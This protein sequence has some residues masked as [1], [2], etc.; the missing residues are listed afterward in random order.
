MFFDSEFMRLYEELCVI[1]STPEVSLTE[2]KYIEAGPINLADCR[3]ITSDVKDIRG[4]Y[5]A[6]ACLEY[7]GELT[8]VQVRTIIMRET[9]HGKEFLGKDSGRR[10]RLPGGGFD[11]NKDDDILDT[12]DREAYEEFNLTLTNLKDTGVRIWSH[13]KD[14]WVTKHVEKEEDRWTGYYTIY[15][16]AEVSGF[17]DNVHPEEKGRWNWLPIE[18]LGAVNPKL[19][20]CVDS[21]NEAIRPDKKGRTDLGEV[22]YLCDKLS[23]LRKILSRMEIQKT[24]VSEVRWEKGKRPEQFSPDG[25]PNTKRIKQMSLSTSRDL[26][27]HANRRPDKWGFGVI[28]D[29]KDLS[30]YYDMEAYNHADHKLSELNLN[31]IVKLTPQ[32]AAE[33]G[34]SRVIIMLGVYGNR[35]VSHKDE[36]DL[37]LYNYLMNFLNNHPEYLS[38]VRYLDHYLTV[39][40]GA[41]KRGITPFGRPGSNT[42]WSDVRF[43]HLQ[44][45]DI[46]DLYAWNPKQ[47]IPFAELD[48]YYEG[49]ISELLGQYTSF[50]E[51]EER[52]WMPNPLMN[53]IQIPKTSLTGIILPFYFKEDFEAAQ[54]INNDI[55]WLKNFV[56]EHNLRV[57][58]H[59]KPNDVPQELATTG[60]TS[61]AYNNSKQYYQQEFE[62]NDT[63]EKELAWLEADR[64]ENDPAKILQS[65]HKLKNIYAQA[66]NSKQQEKILAKMRPASVLATAAVKLA[67]DKY[68]NNLTPSTYQFKYDIAFETAQ[69]YLADVL[70][71]SNQMLSKNGTLTPSGTNRLKE[72]FDYY[73]P[74]CPED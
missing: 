53:F 54:P 32:A 40:T 23:V 26:I 36:A 46:E 45:E 57:E 58:W 6:S 9:D 63:P 71:S 30:K 49:E 4:E 15:V 31:K 70:V 50:D 5:E 34:G 61:N 48:K 56:K 64:A 74:E 66:T 52:I 43:T 22:S 41:W 13:R 24:Y 67:I 38:N 62:K 60:V 1:N 47:G 10:V 72:L 17:G 25:K 2:A 3:M 68:M 18:K 73:C 8:R 21:L 20:A 69:D 16:T 33:F 19:P 12:A 42:K 29:A 35:L 44:P 55:A 14:S 27:G 65:A 51:K 59:T 28:L 37:R 39:K 7:N 11:M